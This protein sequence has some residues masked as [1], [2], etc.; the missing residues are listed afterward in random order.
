MFKENSATNQSLSIAPLVSRPKGGMSAV[1]IVIASSNSSP[2]NHTTT[3]AQGS[4]PQ[5]ASSYDSASQMI[6]S[7][8]SSY[9]TVIEYVI[10][11]CRFSLARARCCKIVSIII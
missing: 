11:V 7:D 4:L 9:S 1:P 3:T 6:E 5:L 8:D 2:P 10:E